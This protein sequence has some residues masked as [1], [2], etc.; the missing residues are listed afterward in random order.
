MAIALLTTLYGS[1]LANLVFIPMASKLAMR[2]E[3]EVFMKQIII[4]GVVGIQSGQNP[5]ILEEKL[6]VFLSHD[7]LLRYA[8]RQQEGAAL[9]EA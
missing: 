9:D 5:R 8:Q 2:T 1:L 7:E 6:K 3:K 4:E